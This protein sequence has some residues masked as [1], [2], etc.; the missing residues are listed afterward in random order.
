MGIIWGTLVENDI[1]LS[2]DNIRAQRNFS[3][4]IWNIARFVF[5]HKTE[6]TKYKMPSRKPRAKNDDDKFILNELIITTK[7]V[8]KALDK[9]RLNEAAKEIYSFVW[10]KFASNYVEKSKKE[11]DQAQPVLEY[12]LLQS[13]KLLHPF[14]PFVTEVIYQQNFASGKKDL[15]ITSNWPT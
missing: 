2:E 15:L 13:L 10:N 9:H 8:T 11:R 6:N 3:N 5:Q 14:M 7:K 1:A 4:K 12:V